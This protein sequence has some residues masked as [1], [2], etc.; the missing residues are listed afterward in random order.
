MRRSAE[1][2]VWFPAIKAGSGTDVFTQ[3]L[4]KGLRQRGIKAEIT[5]LPHRAEYAPWTVTVPRVPGWANIAHINTWLHPRFIPQNLRVVATIH[6]CVHD[7]HLEAFKT[8]LQ[9]LYHRLWIRLVEA[10]TLQRA[11]VVTAVS[12]YSANR[13]L[14]V[15]RCQNIH[16]IYNGVDTKMFH[17]LPRSKPNT[18][19]R[20]LYV[21][22]W[23]ERKGADLLAPILRELGDGFELVYTTDR[24][25]RHRRYK[26]PSNCRSLGRLNDNELVRA[27]QTADALLFPSRLEGFGLVAA[28]AMACG[29]PVIGA[30]ASSLPEVVEHGKTGFLCPVDDVP[31]F[32]AAVR[33]LASDPALWQAMRRGASQRVHKLFDLASQIERYVLIYRQV[34]GD[35][36]G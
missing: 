11:D 19:F 12:R 10:R 35:C 13:T 17:P 18:P 23:S 27:Y 15:F 25:G 14:E 36:D 9:R 24:S 28:E 29:L 22:N 26:L 21:G 3:R 7:P 20:L 4:V 31:A 30:A 6:L 5:W 8:P 16:V 2:A 34:S 32:A 33:N 1:P